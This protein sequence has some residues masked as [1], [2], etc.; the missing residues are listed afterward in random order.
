MIVRSQLF[1]L[2][3]TIFSA[4]ACVVPPAEFC[5]PSANLTELSGCIAMCDL[6][7]KCGSNAVEATQLDCYCQQEIL[8]SIFKYIITF[9]NY[10][11]LA[12]QQG[13]KI[14]A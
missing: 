8:S 4:N 13:L 9:V 14:I 7:D 11:A 12:E 5:L 10:E 6:E 3:G 2:A 1:V